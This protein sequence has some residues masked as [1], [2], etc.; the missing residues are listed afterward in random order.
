VLIEVNPKVRIPRT[1]KRFS[2]LMVQL[3]HK[4][5][6]RSAT[7]S[8]VLLKASLRV[9]LRL[10]V[11]ICFYAM[12]S[13]RSFSWRICLDFASNIAP[14]FSGKMAGIKKEIASP[15]DSDSSPYPL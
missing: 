9:S 3:L 8:E 12:D 2:G 14:Y 10:C 7:N 4:L 15:I 13:Y 1:Y 11:S 5:K 6:I